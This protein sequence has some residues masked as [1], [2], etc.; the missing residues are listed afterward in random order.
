MKKL[1][2]TLLLAACGSNPPP[3]SSAVTTGSLGA[4]QPGT[5]DVAAGA[6]APTGKPA[7]GKWGFDSNGMDTKVAP[8]ASFYQYAN[9]GWL[10]STPIPEDKSNYGMFT[11][12]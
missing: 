1:L 2:A 9:G 10:K 3:K 4:V 12:L 11:V 8:G 5:V 7:Y 6:P